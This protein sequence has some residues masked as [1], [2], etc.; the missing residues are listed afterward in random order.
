QGSKQPKSMWSLVHME[1]PTGWTIMF[2]RVV[3]ATMTEGPHCSS[4]TVS[5]FVV[6]ELRLHFAPRR[7]SISCSLES[8]STIRSVSIEKMDS[9]L[10]KRCIRIDTSTLGKRRW[11]THMQRMRLREETN[12]YQF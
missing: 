11:I 8:L 10:Q 12:D 1:A 3:P 7:S 9:G 5:G 6:Q 2:W 4:A